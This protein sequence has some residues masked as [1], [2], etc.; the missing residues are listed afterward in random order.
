M[1]KEFTLQD[2][3]DAMH[4]GRKIRHIHFES[5][6]YIYFKNGNWKCEKGDPAGYVTFHNLNEWSYYEEPKKTEKRT[7][8]SPVVFHK[9][10]NRISIS[11]DWFAS[12]NETILS[13]DM[14]IIDWQEREFEIPM[15]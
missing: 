15:E 10:G 2:I 7:F 13:D 3:T 8:Y 5:Y 1:P 11:Y 12:K 14:Y 9:S 6:E 4:S